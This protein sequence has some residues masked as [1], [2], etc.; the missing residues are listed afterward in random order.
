MGWLFDSWLL[1]SV[2][3]PILDILILALIFYRA[4]TI[5]LQTRAVQLVRGTLLIIL[6]Y[7]FAY[8]LRLE[9]V[10]WLLNFLAPSLVIGIAI[11]FQPE[12]RK[13]FTQLGQGKIFRFKET[14]KPLQIDGVLKASQML[15]QQRRGA[16]VVF[17]RSV[18]QKNIVETGSTLNAELSSAL[19]ITIFGSDTPL[20]D[21]AVIIEDGKLIAAGAFLPLSEQQDIRRSFG[22]RHRAALGLA[23][24]SDAVILVVSEETGAISL[25]Y[26]ATLYYDLEPEEVRSR[27]HELLNLDDEDFE[28]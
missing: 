19:L 15:A 13:I 12:L 4:Y 18:G 27:L 8:I 14:A 25:A 26:D 24:E 6:L 2:I 10:L 11:I 17:V 21:G 16:L 5:F 3:I 1:G 20:H 7:A 28:Q 22:T 23:E 9:T